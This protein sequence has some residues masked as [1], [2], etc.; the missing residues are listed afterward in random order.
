MISLAAFL[1]CVRQAKTEA[2]GYIWGKYGQVWTQKDQNAATR[3]TTVKYGSRWIGRRVCDC[4]G[5]IRYAFTEN[6]AT[7]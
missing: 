5:L 1:A 2:W 3:E 7:I 6:G 4:S